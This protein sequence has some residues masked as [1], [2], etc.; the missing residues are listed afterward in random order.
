MKIT[1]IRIGMDNFSYLVQCI[2]TGKAAL[3]DPGTNASEA[4][5]L[6][7]HGNLQLIFIINTHR[8]LDH[9]A[10]NSRVRETYGCDIIASEPESYGI[11]DVTRTVS[12]GEILM[13]GDVR[14]RFLLTPGHTPGGLCMLVD[15]EA[16]LTGDT[17]FIGDCGRTDMAGGSD[18]EMF[19]SLQKIK[20]LPDAVI[21]YPGHD[22]GPVPFD[23]LGNQKK[24]NKTLLAKSANELSLI[25]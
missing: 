7:G 11:S 8:H 23:T 24:Q 18:N 2:A 10:E 19:L 13:L 20:S 12:D 3:V 6:I 4:M 15:G 22:Y 25:A 16:L 1:Q 14:I 17:L 9:V 5:S 21:I